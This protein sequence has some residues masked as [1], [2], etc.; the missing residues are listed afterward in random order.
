MR[1]WQSE[2]GL[3]G[4]TVRSVA[5]SAD[6]YLW[7]ATAEGVVRF[8]G[9]R[10]AGFN[11]EPDAALARR[12]PRSLFA[13][14]DG[15][16]WIATVQEGLLRWRGGRLESVWDDTDNIVTVPVTQVMAD[17]RGGAFI[18]RGTELWHCTRNGAPQRME[19]TPELDARLQ[20]DADASTE[21]GHYFSGRK[22]RIS[23]IA[24]A[25]CGG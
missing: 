12:P 21:R 13:L 6:G 14:P 20:A 24:R 7:V 19:R 16:V 10:F 3:P 18:L 4:N 11:A 15:D 23:A 22:A 2:D 25:D 9:E 17:D 8:D 5:Q 1:P